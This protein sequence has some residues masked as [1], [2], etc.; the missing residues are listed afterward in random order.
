M[1][2]QLYS[3]VRIAVKQKKGWKIS[4]CAHTRLILA[5]FGVCVLPF[6]TMAQGAA[7]RCLEHIASRADTYGQI[8][9]QIWDF[10]EVG[11]QEYKS[12]ALLQETLR[13][14]GFTVRS[15]IA[16]MPTAFI[17]EAGAG[18]PVIGILGEF[19]A[20]PGVSQSNAPYRDP[21]PEVRAGHACG[22]HLFGVASA[23][24]AI[25]IR[26]WLSSTGTG[27]T[28]RYYGTPA[29]EGGAGKVYFVREG[30]FDDV[31][32]VIHWHPS[33]GNN[34]NASSSLANISAKFRFYGTSA[35]ASGAP[36]FGRS[37]LDGVEA[38]NH[39]VNMLRE[40]IPHESRIHHV[41][42][43]GGEAP[44]VVPEFAEVFYYCRHPDITQAR[45]NFEWI[46]KAAEGAALGTQ[47]RMDYEVIHGLHSILPNE[48]LARVMY[49]NLNI[50]G[51]VT[52][53]EEEMAY[54][55]QLRETLMN[56][57]ANFENARIIAPFKIVERGTG[58]STDVGDISW[59]VPTVGMYVATWVPG[60]SSH[61]WQAV[62]AGG[63]SIGLK[64]MIVAA[65]T[66]ALTAIDMYSDPDLIVRAYEELER[67]RGKNF[68]YVPLIGD[69]Q[70]PL[71]YRN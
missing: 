20:L 15:N 47:T 56:P 69:R 41:I 48:T 7:E 39:M 58:G 37:A 61:S 26:D 30:Y 36:H 16:G 44:N 13:A 62:A 5:Y 63:T 4:F 71:D 51:G 68:R 52:Y 42:T 35:H 33:N 1:T 12:S 21:R 46:V 9:L 22:H 40:H 50:I 25:A 45:E 28:I 19:D 27:G 54:A 49:K 23:A 31:D 67:R 32:A 64:G 18:T 53:D 6:H 59:N 10:A 65:K 70:P 66:M 11:Y 8:A 3:A 57:D 17:A 60:T 43:H 29:E 14:G 2:L 24:T 55:M 34:A 38:M